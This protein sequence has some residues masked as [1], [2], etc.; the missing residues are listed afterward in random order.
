[1]HVLRENF[2]QSGHR[3][4][5]AVCR[6]QASHLQTVNAK[7]VCLDSTEVSGNASSALKVKPAMKIEKAAETV[8]SDTNVYYK[9]ISR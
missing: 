2:Q 7:N 5:S 1:M 6:E 3:L 8:K 4:A 9:N